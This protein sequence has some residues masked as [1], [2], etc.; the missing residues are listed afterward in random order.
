MAVLRDD[1]AAHPRIVAYYIAEETAGLRKF[2]ISELPEFMIPED[3]V[4]L[5]EFPRLPNGKVDRKSLPVPPI[6]SRGRG[7]H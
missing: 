7:D 3:L 5:R 6:G 1:V 4:A 2:L